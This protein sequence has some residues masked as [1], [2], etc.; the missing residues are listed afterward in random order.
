MFKDRFV[1]AK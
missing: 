1:A